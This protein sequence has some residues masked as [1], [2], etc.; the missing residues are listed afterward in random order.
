MDSPGLIDKLPQIHTFIV[1]DWRLFK[2]RE[3][4]CLVQLV[5]YQ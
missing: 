3:L 1:R 5:L 2:A 4:V